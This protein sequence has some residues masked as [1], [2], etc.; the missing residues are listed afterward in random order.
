MHQTRSNWICRPVT[1]KRFYKSIFETRRQVAG[2]SVTQLLSYCLK[3]R[4]V[5]KQHL[6]KSLPALFMGLYYRIKWSSNEIALEEWTDALGWNYA[7]IMT[8][9]PHQSLIQLFALNNL[10]VFSSKQLKVLLFRLTI[11][12]LVQLCISHGSGTTCQDPIKST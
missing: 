5:G 6:N 12:M 7:V 2:I 4:E 10:S 1:S 3:I 8:N 9:E 11:R